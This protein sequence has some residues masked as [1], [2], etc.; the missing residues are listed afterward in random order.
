MLRTLP[1]RRQGYVDGDIAAADDDNPRPDPHRLAAAHGMQEV[2]PAEHE[3][4][5]DT[6]DRDEARA[7]GAKA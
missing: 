5:L 7:L 2:D 4:L 1:Q 6:L 3:G